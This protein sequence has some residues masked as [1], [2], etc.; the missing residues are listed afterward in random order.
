MWPFLFNACIG[1]LDL[2]ELELFGRHFTQANSLETPTFERLDR[3]LVSTVS[4]HKFPLATQA[5]TRDISYHTPLVC[6]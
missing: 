5:L 4:E 3:F 2:R 6:F 1:S